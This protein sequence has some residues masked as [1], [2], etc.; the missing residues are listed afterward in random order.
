MNWP[1]YMVMAARNSKNN[2]RHW[3]RYL[4]KDIDKL[5]SLFFIEDVECLCKNDELS[6]FQK[7]SLR[8]AFREGSPTREYIIFLNSRV[9]PNKLSIVRAKIENDRQKQ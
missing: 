3:F 1:Q 7:V 8:A 6:S 2:A 9:V 5:G 4:R